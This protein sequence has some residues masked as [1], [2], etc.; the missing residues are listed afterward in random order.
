VLTFM[1]D[2][3]GASCGSPHSVQWTY[4]TYS[5]ANLV[6]ASPLVIM[7][8]R[9]INDGSDI[10]TVADTRHFRVAWLLPLNGATGFSQPTTQENGA[11]TNPPGSDGVYTCGAT[12]DK[13][14]DDIPAVVAL[15]SR[16]ACTGASPCLDIDANKVFAF[17]ASTGGGMV[18]TTVCDT[19]TSALFR[20]GSIVSAHRPTL[21]GT[22]S[23]SDGGSC[24]ALTGT[25]NGWNGQ[26]TGLAPNTDISLQFEYA[27][28]DF[29]CPAS[30][31][32]CLRT[33]F[34]DPSGKWW[35]GNPQMAGDMNPP[36]PSTS[37][38]TSVAE[39]HSIGCPGTPT[40]TQTYGANSRLIRNDYVGCTNPIRGTETIEAS[41]SSCGHAYPGLVNCG[42]TAF[43][44]ALDAVDFL[45]VH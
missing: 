26:P 15:V 12:G 43:N 37:A 25:S 23:Q 34:V 14:C 42:G 31:G 19:R 16:V 20:G 17:G 11:C 8:S 44:P 6:G 32:N 41:D 36:A 9:T 27:D 7:F 21:T 30:Q 22:T 38:G 13:R 45:F 10:E 35:Y 18:Q 28:N 39:G 2:D 5:P 29:T 40:L 24:P 4:Q 3:G 33:G 1:A